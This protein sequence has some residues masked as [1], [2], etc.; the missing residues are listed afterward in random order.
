MTTVDWQAKYEQAQRNLAELNRDYRQTRLQVANLQARLQA[1][2]VLLKTLHVQDSSYP[3]R[4][5]VILLDDSADPME[6]ITHGA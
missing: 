6:Y 1:A 5:E 4:D 3:I 2:Q